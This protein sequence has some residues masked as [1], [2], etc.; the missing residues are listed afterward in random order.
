MDFP[1]DCTLTFVLHFRTSLRPA[2]GADV[3]QQL[4]TVVP[5]PPPPPIPSPTPTKRSATSTL[6][7]PSPKREC[8]VA[9]STTA[10]QTIDSPAVGC[11][12]DACHIQWNNGGFCEH[13]LM[14]CAECDHVWDGNAQCTHPYA[15]DCDSA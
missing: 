11:A 2:Y 4:G 9:T 14:K 5:P 12:S 6:T 7:T 13:D 1:F 3:H 15:A 8:P 10:T